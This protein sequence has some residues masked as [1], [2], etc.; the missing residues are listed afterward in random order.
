[1]GDP[2]TSVDLVNADGQR[3]SAPV[4]QAAGLLDRGFRVETAGEQSSALAKG[5]R[6]DIYG[7]TT[8]KVAAGLAGLARGATVGLSD[9]GIKALGGGDAL[10]KLR[11]VNP[12]TSTAAEIVGGV[13]PALLP[14]LGAA[15]AAQVAKLGS[16]V[17]ALSEGAGIV[18]KTAANVAG[19]AL[20]GGIQSAGQYLGQTA[21]EDKPV[22]AE[23]FWGAV[24]S[25]ALLGGGAAGGLAL[26]EGALL[27]A[28]TLFPRS[29]VT[30]EAAQEAE[31]AVSTELTSA[32]TDGDQ[33]LQTARAELQKNR[34]LRSASDLET[35]QKVN[36]LKI[37]R[38]EQRLAR[39]QLKTE[40]AT[41][42]TTK[43]VKRTRKAFEEPAPDAVPE[44][45][46]AAPTPPAAA[47]DDL[48]AQLQATKQ[49]IDDG[50]TIG[51]LSKRTLDDE[52]DDVVAAS[53]PAHAKL[54]DATRDLDDA[55]QRMDAW[56][57][58][59]QTGGK[60]GKGEVS[61]FERGQ[62]S[63]D[64][65]GGMRKSEGY[66]DAVP[67]GEGNVAMSRGR[68]SVWR[69][70]EE[71]RAL[72]DAKTFSKLVPE[73][74]VAA[75]QAIEEMMSRRSVARDI[76][77]PQVEQPIE[78]KIAA[79]LRE[80]VGEHVDSSADIAE[81]ALVIG[82]YEEAAANVADILGPAAPP[83]AQVRAAQL[84]QASAN[85]VDNGTATVAEMARDI[86][87][88]L[89][90]DIGAASPKLMPS[91]PS[92][93]GAAGEGAGMIK[94]AADIGTVLEV[95][96]SLGLPGVPDLKSLPV[97]GPVLSLYLKARAASAVYRKLGGKVPANTETI[98]A[99]HAAE[100]RNRVE[101][102]VD[103]MLDVSATGAR[104]ARAA[105]GPLAALGTRLFDAP[106]ERRQGDA[107]PTKKADPYRDYEARI[108]ELATASQPGMVAD[109]VRKSVPTADPA[110][111]AALVGAAERKLAFLN[112]KAPKQ[113]K[114]PT[115]L[116]GDGDWKPS[117]MQLEQFGRY[118]KAAEDPASVLEDLANTGSVTYEAA[119]T[120][121]NV[122]PSL[123]KAAQMRLVQKAGELQQKLPY[124]R[125]VSLSILFQVPVD[126]TMDSDY[127]NFLRAGQ[128]ANGTAPAQGSPG[129]APTP[130][131][132][133]AGP[134][135][136][137]D[138]SMTRLDRRAGA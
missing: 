114:L 34:V 30:R 119:D 132:T 107:K 118:I 78:S 112:E 64:W 123:Y 57:A 22:S 49:G 75:D 20:E 100:T 70:S 95:M 104:K 46:A 73:E 106:P 77:T 9:I 85:Q 62:A 130:T 63:R 37:A 31:R 76:V 90:P 19:G 82:R 72:E 15:P 129:A 53:D 127:M 116:R 11:E 128:P 45:A 117:R 12:Y 136:L 103:K 16:K 28:K 8:G 81:A 74:R 5:V 59:Y 135:M 79:A 108:H 105:V 48:L 134:V 84:R 18:G 42:R 13:A 86:D 7:G 33:L 17:T 71:A 32:A 25:G 21:L 44:A 99:K 54:L 40:Q 111:Q 97:I 27:K 94:K 51:Q 96:S 47:G 29:E 55:K 83:T 50:K 102:A 87:K 41:A 14:G 133:A 67:A 65:A 93:M 24:G 92:N 131:P 38:E 66:V 89:P 122:Y 1:V 120:L 68:Q 110:L 91:T 69:G 113:M 125:R 43:G 115:L 101:Q 56:L 4:E 10:Q 137:G 124:A 35:T 2:V 60:Y 88:K 121:R 6:E 80:H 126:G 61:S 23:G 36:A 138:R 39:E 98:I 26:T 109:A 3:I 52:V 58:K